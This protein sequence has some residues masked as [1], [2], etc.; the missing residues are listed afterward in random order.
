MLAA[1]N[2]NIFQ[3]FSNGG[4]FYLDNHD[5]VVTATTTQHIY[6]IGETAAGD[7]FALVHDYDLSSALTSEE[8]ITSAL[9]DSNGLLWFVA[10]R[11]GVVGTLDTSTGDV[12]VIRLGSGSEGEIESRRS[13]GV[14][15]G[16]ENVASV[17][18][19]FGSNMYSSGPD[20]L[21]QID[22][23]CP[24]LSNAIEPQSRLGAR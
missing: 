20:V 14:R 17:A 15:S 18:S 11:D 4:Y 22:T 23:T 19:V 21:M 3:D 24:W 9:P 7:G 8:E 5:E 1:V 2:P 16:S 13:S 6:V 10:R 12:H